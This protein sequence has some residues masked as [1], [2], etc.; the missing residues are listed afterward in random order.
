MRIEWNPTEANKACG[1][2]MEQIASV[3]SHCIP[4]GSVNLILEGHITRI[5]LSF[6][7]SGANMHDFSVSAMLRRN[8]SGKYEQL[9]ETYTHA[10]K[11]NSRYLG[12]ADSN[13]YLLIY[14]KWAE[15]ESPQFAGNKPR[16]NEVYEGRYRRARPLSWIRFELT[17]RQVG[18]WDSLFDSPNPFNR[19]LVAQHECIPSALRGYEGVF[20]AAACEKFGTQAALSLIED[21]KLRNRYAKALRQ[22]G[23]PDWWKPEEIWSELGGAFR[24][25]MAVE[26]SECSH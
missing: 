4:G 26:D 1:D 11:I 24:A 19:Y 2:A 9:H 16:R 17:L 22:A 8:Q 3:L 10:G 25:A 14:D 15:R 21:T 20:F 12:K 5:D 13:K 7:L 23:P 18:S 6:D